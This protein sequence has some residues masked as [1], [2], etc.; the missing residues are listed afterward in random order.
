[1][2]RRTTARAA[3]VALAFLPV[4]L[5]PTTAQAQPSAPAAGVDSRTGEGTSEPDESTA[6]EEIAPRGAV[7]Y[8]SKVV[9]KTKKTKQTN[10]KNEIARC[11]AQSKGMTCTINKTASATRTID[12]GFGLSRGAVAGNLGISKAKTQSVAVSCT[13]K[14]KKG[15]S[16]VAYPIGTKYRYKIE[17]HMTANGLPYKA[18]TSGWKHA[19]NPSPASVSC[20]VK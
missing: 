1:M 10:T 18:G 5:A 7:G 15:H 19:F 3:A 8:Y 17:K 9:K 2:N 6:P 14:V 16:L 20:K 11:T 13:S 12:A 4:A